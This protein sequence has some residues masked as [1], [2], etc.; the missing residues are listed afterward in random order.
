MLETLGFLG[1]K[2]PSFFRELGRRLTK[3]TED[4]RK[5]AFLFQGTYFAVQLFNAIRI[6]DNFPVQVNID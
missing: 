5:T 1:T 2:T 4:T 3:A 6:R